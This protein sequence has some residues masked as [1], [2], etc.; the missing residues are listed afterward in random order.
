MKWAGG[1]SQLLTQ[2]EQLYPRA[3]HTRKI[4]NYVEPFIGGGAVFFDLMQRFNFKSA[5]ISDINADLIAIYQVIQNKVD[6]LI[7]C[8]RNYQDNY[9]RLDDEKRLELFLQVR[10]QFNQRHL[11]HLSSIEMATQLIFLNKTCFN[12]LFRVNSKGG[13][14]VPF[15]RYAN[16]AILQEANLML[17]SRI[18]QNVE[19]KAAN[20]DA[21]FDKVNDHTFVYFD[22]PYHPL[23][24]T[25]SFT[26]YSVN[27]FGEA[28]QTRLKLLCDELD[29]RGCKILLSNSNASFIREL[30]NDSRY[31][32][33]EVQATRA[34]NSVGAKRGKINELLV[35]NKYEL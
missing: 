18:L 24:D 27:G 29:K 34:I 28:Q 26:G 7:G 11:G 35:H 31:E 2:F 8:L 30:Y 23:S 3:L 13:F 12:G 20:Y 4:T 5:Y 19:I 14:N 17:V 21:C 32:I 22:P 15:G 10:E 33:V 1:K 16:P 6:E 9:M 25:S